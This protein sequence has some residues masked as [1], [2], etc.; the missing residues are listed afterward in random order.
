MTSHIPDF[1]FSSPTGSDPE[2]AAPLAPRGG[3][4]KRSVPSKHE[5]QNSKRPAPRAFTLVE[6]LVVMAIMGLM[7]GLA[8][9]AFNSATRGNA[10]TAGAS[11]VVN[12]LMLARAK[13]ITS[14]SHVR[15]I[16]ADTPTNNTAA[17]NKTAYAVLLWTNQTSDIPANWIYLDRWQQLPKGAYFLLLPGT[18]PSNVPFPTNQVVGAGI[19]MSGLE[20]KSTGA[21]TS[22]N[23]LYIATQEGT[24]LP[25]GTIGNI[26]AANTLSNQVFSITGVA[27]VIR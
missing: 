18:L 20:F 17:N 15:V 26:R 22:Q 27:K 19:P 16:F 1:A 13:A 8:V 11:Q 2:G 12:T 5:S 14:R 25:N 24:L 3:L 10:V 23:D 21:L 4:R 9:P 6:L 7:L